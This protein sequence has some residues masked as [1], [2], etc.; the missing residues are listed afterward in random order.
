M[1]LCGSNKTV[2][3]QYFDP[4]GPNAEGQHV[5]SGG[6]ELRNQI[7]GYVPGMLEQ[8]RYDASQAANA[9]KAGAGQFAPVL[10][11]AQSNLRGDYLNGNP[12]LDRAVATARNASDTA[13][14]SAYGRARADFSGAQRT[15]QSQYNRAGQTFGTGLQQSQ[16]A[17]RAAL[18][19]DIARAEAARQ[20]QLAEAEMGARFNNYQQE[21]AYQN[22]SPALLS[23]AAEKPFQMLSAVPSVNASGVL[24]SAELVGA[25]AGG[26]SV[27]T[28]NT[29][30]KPGIFDYALQGAGTAATAGWF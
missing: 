12:A 13:A 19:A 7:F 14:Q 29:Y 25:L 17:S 23:M 21:R 30:Y 18:N 20:A 3:P 16:D 2:A 5:G 11:Y 1:G 28:P 6:P 10:S 15:L 26:G 8:G 22:Q 24:P 27:V 4:L 9:A